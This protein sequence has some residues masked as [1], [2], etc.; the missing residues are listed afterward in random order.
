M[1]AGTI[2]GTPVGG[3]STFGE[4]DPAGFTDPS[5]AVRQWATSD[6]TNTSITPSTD[7][8]QSKVSVSVSSS[9][10]VGGSYVLTYTD[11]DASGNLIGTSG[12]ITVP[13]LPAAVAPVD[14]V[15]NQLS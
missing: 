3:T 9:A 15:V 7:P 8:T 6:T 4:T 12:P 11:T 5:G 14:F 13:F 2:K 10:P 1:S